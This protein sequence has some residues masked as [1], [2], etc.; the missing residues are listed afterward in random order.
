MSLLCGDS[1]V[2]CLAVSLTVSWRAG[3]G[4]RASSGGFLF[5]VVLFVFPVPPVEFFAVVAGFCGIVYGAAEGIKHTDVV[6][7]AA[8][9]IEFYIQCIRVLPGEF[10]Y[11]AYADV[12]EVERAGFADTGNGL[13]FFQ[14]LLFAHGVKIGVFTPSLR[15][16]RVK[17]AR[18]LIHDTRCRMPD[19]IDG[20]VCSSPWPL[21]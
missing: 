16:W 20:V 15:L 14:Y 3:I 5:F 2:T 21:L 13:Q 7:G 4:Y 6:G 18:C 8:V 19:V 9:F 11:A 10:C 1:F 12:P 17:D